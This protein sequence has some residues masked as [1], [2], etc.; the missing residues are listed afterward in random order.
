MR[1]EW[2]EARVLDGCVPPLW[3][4]AEGGVRLADG[5]NGGG[6]LGLVMA[7]VG[8]ALW[9]PDGSKETG[10]RREAAGP[11]EVWLWR[12]ENIGCS[13]TFS[14]LVNLFVQV[15]FLCFLMLSLNCS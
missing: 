14:T 8:L 10:H 5:G 11:R 13:D 4:P 9:S 12:T 15:K 7:V 3:L 2:V 1:A 6:S